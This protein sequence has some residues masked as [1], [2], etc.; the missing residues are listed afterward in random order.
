MPAGRSVNRSPSPAKP[1]PA[2]TVV[3]GPADA[4]NTGSQRADALPS[5]ATKPSAELKQ[6]TVLSA[7]VVDSMDLA[8]AVGVERFHEIITE[9][10]DRCAVIVQRYGGMIDKSTGE[11][12]I[13]VFGAPA[14]LEDHALRACLAALGIQQEANGLAD[15][16][17][18]H[19]GGDLR[20]RIGLTSGQVIAGGARFGFF[21]FGRRAGRDGAARGGRRRARRGHAQRV[22]RPAGRKQGGA[23]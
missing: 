10:V 20:L 13:A 22:V 17:Q 15:K 14:A 19:D 6:V 5:A 18:R 2:P 8:A 7:S 9:L 3:E 4:T 21:G 12:I 23:G 16:V 11:G 1:S